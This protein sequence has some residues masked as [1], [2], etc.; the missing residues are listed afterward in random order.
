MA[1]GVALVVATVGA[2]V[3]QS[4]PARAAVLSGTPVPVAGVDAFG[5]GAGQLGNPGGL[6]LDSKNDVFVADQTNNRVLEYAFVPFVPATAAYV[7]VGAIV[8]GAGGLGSGS[9]QLN[10]PAAVSLDAKGDLFVADSGNNRVVEYALNATSGTYAS[11]GT[12]VA[13]SGGRD[14]APLSWSTRAR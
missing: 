3:T 10:S 9:T 1:T 13:G 6:V 8:A 4:P 5:I 12:T 11:T 7:K 2:L 14:R